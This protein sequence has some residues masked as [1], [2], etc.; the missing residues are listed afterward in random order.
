MENEIL[1][2]AAILQKQSEEINEHLN[3]LGSQLS[4]L[5]ELSGNISKISLSKDN[6]SISSLGKGIFVKS[7]LS[8]ENLFVNVGAGVIV[9][10]SPEETVNAISS[11]IKNIHEAR[12]HLMQQL[13]LCNHALQSAIVELENQKKSADDRSN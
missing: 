2:K 12:T 3:Y 1:F 4:E 5:E 8:P 7:V 6:E 9:K 10:K 11:Q 13:E